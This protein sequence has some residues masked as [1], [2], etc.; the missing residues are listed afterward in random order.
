MTIK[1]IVFSQ[2]TQFL[3]LLEWRL[4]RSGIRYTLRSQPLLSLAYS[5]DCRCVKLDGRM[6]PTQR[7]AVIDAFNTHPQITVFLVSLKVSA[8]FVMDYRR[9]IIRPIRREVLL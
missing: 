7:Q 2:F 8:E 5:T 6:S 4:Q 1:S 9:Y 3:D